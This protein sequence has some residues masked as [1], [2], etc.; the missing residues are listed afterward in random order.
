MA[1]RISVW[2]RI[3]DWL[4]PGN[5]RW[6]A[7]NRSQAIIEFDLEGT[8]LT[9]NASFLSLMG[10]TLTELQGKPHRQLVPASERESPAYAAFWQALRRGEHQVGQVPRLTRAGRQVWLQAT[11]TPVCNAAGRPI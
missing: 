7:V 5:Q 10:Y 8:V 6:A 3:T 2:T 1:P 11:Y 4:H 9:A